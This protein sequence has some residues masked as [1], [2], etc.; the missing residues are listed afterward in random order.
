MMPSTFIKAA[1][2]SA[3]HSDTGKILM[4]LARHMIT[5]GVEASISANAGLRLTSPR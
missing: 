5:G 2:W 1:C 4:L 3:S